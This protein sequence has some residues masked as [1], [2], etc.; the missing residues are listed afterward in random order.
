MTRL[1][2][3]VALALALAGCIT[4]GAPAPGVEP[5]RVQQITQRVC[6]Y[7]PTASSIAALAT[8][9]WAD[10]RPGVDLASRIANA[11][12]G[13]LAARPMYEGPLVVRGVP[14][15]GRYVRA[16]RRARR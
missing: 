4:V 9:F 7:L 16:S 8:T 11:I 13:E 10:A 1:F 2:V 15:Q 14:I 6:G 5:T 12:C 3:V